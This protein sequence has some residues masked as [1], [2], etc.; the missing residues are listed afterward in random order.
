M[1]AL[2]LLALLASPASAMTCG[3]GAYSGATHSLSKLSKAAS[4]G[5]VTILAIGSSSTAGT[6]AGG[7]KTAYPARTEQILRA[8]LGH[9]RLTVTARGVGGERADG[10]L[11]RLP[12][13]M[14]ETGAA[15]VVWQVGTNDALRRL[16][17]DDVAGTIRRGI[18]LARQARADI[19]LIDPQYFP[20]IAKNTGYA[21]MA[22]TIDTVGIQESVTVIDRFERMRSAGEALPSLLAKDGLHMSRDGHDCLAH[23][24]A[25]AILNGLNKGKV[26][27]S[28]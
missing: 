8:A 19:I 17:P 16:D 11:A 25:R 2:V 23:D 22:A 24:L 12:D 3:D 15:L 13:A 5:P 6:G 10:A 4:A 20:R 21:A 1:R 28:P 27:P 9:D 18:A 14:A 26:V 7:K